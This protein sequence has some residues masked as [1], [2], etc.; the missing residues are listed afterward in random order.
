MALERGIDGGRGTVPARGSS[1]SAVSDLA[2]ERVK[3]RELVLVPCAKRWR[4]L[5]VRHV[6]WLKETP[7]RVNG[8]GSPCIQVG[9][10][11]GLP[12]PNAGMT[13][14][15]DPLT[16]DEVL[17]LM[18]ACR[19]TRVRPLTNRLRKAAGS[20]MF[21]CAGG[22][23]CASSLRMST[24]KPIPP[25]TCEHC[26]ETYYRYVPPCLAEP[27]FCSRACFHAD[28]AV[29]GH[30]SKGRNKPWQDRFW[31]FV[32]PTTADECW[33]WQGMR[34]QQGYGRIST[35][36]RGVLPAHRASY[37]LAHGEIP[38]GL[39]I[40]HRCDNP[41]C[42]NPAHLFLGT[43]DDN[44][45]DMAAKGRAVSRPRIKVP[46]ETVNRVRELRAQG[47]T[48]SQ[49]AAATGVKPGYVYDLMSGRSRRAA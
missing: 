41:P 43:H 35:Q 20:R 1:R 29:N 18:A 27:K 44:M 11:A 10:R 8:N 4:R 45:R 30:P 26:G 6:E 28:V 13:F 12:A 42:V 36:G 3:R 48:G 33:E 38:A 14:P 40:L 15:A 23:S 17:A 22:S 39:H 49:I 25:R 19:T 5:P 21:A 24:K 7:R 9:Y 37:I 31:K 32:T 46:Q 16:P 34:H 47:L 2:L